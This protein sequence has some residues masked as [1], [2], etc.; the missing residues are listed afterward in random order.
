MAMEKHEPGVSRRDFLKGTAAATAAAGGIVPAA[1]IADAAGNNDS[2]TCALSFQGTELLG[3][4]TDSSII[5]NAVADAGIEA[6]V[7]YGKASGVYSDKTAVVTADAEEPLEIQIDKLAPGTRYYYRLMYREKGAKGAFQPRREHAFQTRRPQA[8]AFVFTVISDSHLGWNF[9]N[10]TLYA[11]ACQNVNYDQP[12]LHFD[13]G[14]TFRLTSLGTGDFDGVRRAYL[15]QRPYMGLFA[16]STPVFLVLGNHEEEE[17]WNLDDAG[18]NISES[19]PIMGVNAR[20]RYYPNP[21]PDGFYSGNTDNS[22]KEIDG[23]HLKEDYYAFEWGCALFITLDPYWYTTVKPF[24]GTM[25]GENSDDDTPPADRWRWTLGRNQY[26]WLK[27]TL[28]QSKAK[29]KFVM[30]H[31]VAGGGNVQGSAAPPNGGGRGR[32]GANGGMPGGAGGGRGNGQGGAPPNGGMPGGTG[33]TGGGGYGR[34]GK[35]A[36]R[37]YEWGAAPEDFAANRPG[38]PSDKSIHRLFVDNGVDIFFHGHDHVYAREEVDG[39]I[40]QECPF[41]ANANYGYGFGVYQNDPPGTIV[42]PNSGHLRVSVSPKKVTVDYVRAYLPGDGTNGHVEYSYS[43][44][45]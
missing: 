33:G 10:P 34:G 27:R 21:I 23:D 5:L 29:Y 26:A 20:K 45:K 7:E 32:G 24:V 39:M 30:A 11:I 2:R 3:R 22:Q 13:L 4:P 31:Q 41:P 16:H 35:A 19:K 38:W 18:E 42:K 15:A 43:I 36:T 14:D 8:D 9:N 1:R 25:G 37:D 17:A 44:S 6:Y 40:Y 28:E 12:D